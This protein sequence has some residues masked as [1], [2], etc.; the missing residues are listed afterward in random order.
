MV[1]DTESVSPFC[2]QELLHALRIL[3]LNPVRA[4]SCIR[5]GTSQDPEVS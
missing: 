1:R 3:L 2:R 4:H 5:A